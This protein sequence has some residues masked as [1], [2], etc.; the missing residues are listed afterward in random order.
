MKALKE[1]GIWKGIKYIFTTIAL[2]ILKLMIFSPCRIFF[3]RLLGVRIGKHCVINSIKFFNCYRRGF[4]GLSIGNEC[5]L[6]EDIMIDLANE[7]H[8]GDKVS[9]GARVIIMTHINVGYKDHPL[10]KFFPCSSK[11][12]IIKSG[13]FIGVNS[14]ILSGVEVGECAFI[15]ACSMVSKNVESYTMVAGI[16]AKIIR[17]LSD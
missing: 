5:F 2:C 11:P 15:G 6:G 8:I 13:S 10:Q 4:R 17:T 1:I 3:L 9:I 12:V 16:P 7:V 14:T